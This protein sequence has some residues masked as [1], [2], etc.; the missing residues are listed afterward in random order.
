MNYKIFAR[1]SNLAKDSVLDRTT[2]EAIES[3]S[4]FSLT[5]LKL[6][7]KEPAKI[8]SELDVE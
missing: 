5:F 4:S 7:F 2:Q 8:M 1:I 3:H 6:H